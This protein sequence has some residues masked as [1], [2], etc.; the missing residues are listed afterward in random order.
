[1][2]DLSV[3]LLNDILLIPG[4]NSCTLDENACCFLNPF[5]M[6][7]KELKLKL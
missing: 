3:Y 7:D 4:Y 5:R 2:A 6:I 1:M